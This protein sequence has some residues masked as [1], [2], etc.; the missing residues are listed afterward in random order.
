MFIIKISHSIIFMVKLHPSGLF[1][2]NPLAENTEKDKMPDLQAIPIPGTKVLFGESPLWDGRK[3]ELVFANCFANSVCAF[4]PFSGTLSSKVV[5][6]LEGDEDFKFIVSGIPFS[7]SKDNFLV[8]TS[9]QKLY[10]FDWTTGETVRTLYNLNG[11]GL[12][13]P[14]FEDAKC[15]SKGRL[16]SGVGILSDFGSITTD[17]G[18]GYICV[19]RKLL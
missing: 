14:V 1:N 18:K 10:E 12:I 16:W 2:F 3:K 5:K 11:L 9:T 19:F 15:D 17:K 13:G 8:T 6:P 7:S 4:H